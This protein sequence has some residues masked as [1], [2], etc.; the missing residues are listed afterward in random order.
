MAR[1]VD[2]FIIAIPT[3]NVEAYRKLARKAAIAQRC[4]R[5]TSLQQY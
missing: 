5:A 2:G 3:A 1:Y 4:R